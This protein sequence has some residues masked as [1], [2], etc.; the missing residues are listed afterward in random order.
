MLWWFLLPLFSLAWVEST[1]MPATPEMKVKQLFAPLS[2]RGIPMFQGYTSGGANETREMQKI[3][4][5]FGDTVSVI[6]TLMNEVNFDLREKVAKKY[7]PIHGNSSTAS[8]AAWNMLANMVSENVI[9]Q[10][11]SHGLD[12]D[13]SP[14]VGDLRIIKEGSEKHARYCKDTSWS[15]MWPGT[16]T[17][18]ESFLKAKQLHQTDCNDIGDKL[19]IAPAWAKAK[20]TDMSK[21]AV[22]IHGLSMYPPIAKPILENFSI[23]KNREVTGRGVNETVDIATGP[24]GA[25]DLLKK[26]HPE[27]AFCNGDSYVWF[28][29]ELYLTYKC[30]RSFQ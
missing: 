22:I 13:L 24:Y 15:W 10:R 4:E 1:A 8:F 17:F 11:K 23:C 28:V 18:C 29:T 9:T 5:G 7:F 19:K 3:R 6:G 20:D 26:P 25:R 16:I 2:R 14:A 12:G 21:A 27:K 30:K